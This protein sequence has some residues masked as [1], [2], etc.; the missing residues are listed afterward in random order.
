[1]ADGE[2]ERRQQQQRREQ[3]TFRER[4]DRVDRDVVDPWVPERDD[5]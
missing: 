2:E 1:M 4:E 5:S 3:E